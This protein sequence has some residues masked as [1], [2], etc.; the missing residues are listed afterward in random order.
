MMRLRPGT[1]AMTA[2][3]A[4]MTSLGPLSTDIFVASMPN[5][6]VA[7]TAST[8]TVQLTITCYLVGFAAG[9]IVYGPLSDAIG[10][11]PT[12]RGGFIL[13]LCASFACLFAPTIGVLIAGRVLQG[14]GAAGPIILARAIVR[15]LYEGRAAARQYGVM[16]SITGITPVLA[17]II[18]GFLQSWYGW[19]ASFVVMAAL[20]LLIALGVA[21][22]LPETH[23]RAAP[24]RLSVSSMFQSYRIVAHNRAYLSYLCVQACGYNGIFAFISS[25]SHVMQHVYGL[26]PPQFGAT[27]TACSSSFVVAAFG[28]SRIVARLGID[29]TIGLGVALELLGGVALALG[30]YFFPNDFLSIVLPYM[31]FFL[32]VG[33]TL[34]QTQAAALTPFPERA[35]AASS[36]MGFV[37]MTSGAIVGTIVGATLGE[38]AWPLAVVTCLSGALAFWFFHAGARVRAENRP[39]T[40]SFQPH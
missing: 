5:I 4:S 38:T 21:T 19:R 1:L 40:R 26:S 28:G 34:P 37:Q 11:R 3:L 14:L 24:A 39:I 36:L 20:G 31:I 12:L 33:F 32:G 29:G 35:G 2:L 9:Q 8:A 17:P 18:G 16:S 25:A 30:V 10:R 15:D 6:G 13:Y 7:F 23:A 27:F 22:L